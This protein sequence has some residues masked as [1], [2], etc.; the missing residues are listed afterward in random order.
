MKQVVVKDQV[1]KLLNEL[2]DARRAKAPHLT[3]NKQSIVNDLIVKAWKR[4][5]KQ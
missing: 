5:V 2:V 3:T 1:H 4:E